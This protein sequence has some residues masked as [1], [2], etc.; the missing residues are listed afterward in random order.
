MLLN[1]LCYYAE[2]SVEFY[3]YYLL[4]NIMIPFYTFCNGKNIF[5]FHKT[6]CMLRFLQEERNTWRLLRTLFQDRLDSENM[7]E[8]DMIDTLVRKFYFNSCFNGLTRVYL[9]SY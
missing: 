1:N 9:E 5:S 6:A 8:K 4:C 3:Y 2:L 7:D